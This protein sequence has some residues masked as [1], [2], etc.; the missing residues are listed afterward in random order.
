MP[1]SLLQSIDS[2]TDLRKLPESDLPKLADELRQFIIQTVSKTGG[3]LGAG[4]GVVDLTIALH[5]IFNTPDDR[6]VWDVGHQCYP[7][8]ALTGRRDQLHTLRQKDGVSGF[9]KRSESI[10][11]PFGA[12]HS[13]TSISA[14]LGMAAA[15]RKQKSGNKA[16]AV[17]GDGAMTAG[18][19]FEA[20]NNA[21]HD[22][23]NDLVVVLND[24]EMSI[25][26]NVGAL[27]SYLSKILSGDAYNQIKTGAGT[28]L[29]RLSPTLLDAARRAE[30]HMK[31]MLIPGTL[32][33]ELGFT[34]FGPIDGHDYQ[35]LLPTLRNIKRLTRPILLHVVT[36]KGKGFAPAEDNP[37]TYH[38]VSP[39][40]PDT[41]VMQKSA[42]GP[43]SYTKVF[44]DGLI[45]LA[46]SNPKIV[47]ITA[48]MMEGTGLSAFQK[49]FPERFHDVGIAEQHA[50]TFAGGM[51][52]E[53]EIP[54]CAIYSTFFQRAYDQFVHDVALQNLPVI[55]ALDRAGLVGADGPTHAG[56]YDLSFLRA[57]PNTTIMAP[58]DENELRRML[59]TAAKLGKPA[60]IRYPRGNALGLELEPMTPI[61]VGSARQLRDGADAA[62]LAVG[63]HAHAALAAA[64]T[65]AD[66]GIN[67]AVYDARFIKPLD[68]AMVRAAA[69]TG[70][71]LTVE[72]NA[73]MGGF[74]SAVLEKLSEEGLLA[75]GVRFRSLGIPDRFIP[76][77]S[78]KELRAELGL[79]AE[80]IA[81]AMRA[82]RA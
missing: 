22:R 30:E 63:E 18:M 21:G 75:G 57:I 76:Q 82:L 31:G 58:S 28:V 42:G 47:A 39:F 45:E 77:G 1:T 69:K 55:F 61:P 49:R 9:T 15:A 70:T 20:L 67:C 29:E 16:I 62:I 51:A 23:R 7:H 56:A 44:S 10:Y 68:A 25:S 14:A 78:Q 6:L 8:K 60:V 65:L 12:G 81:A 66:E 36:H 33:E 35:Q 43:P 79:D 64:N 40:D 5:Y 34:Y 53:G 54:V 50:V 32:F 41:G 46:A 3:H 26:P 37:C 13:S 17:I 59:A 74:G 72:E 80:G 71:I 11:D 52:A 2:P 4:L 38:G 73:V 24:N 48:A 27:S 19:A